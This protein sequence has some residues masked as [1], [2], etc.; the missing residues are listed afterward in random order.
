[1]SNMLEALKS[2]W[3]VSDVTTVLAHGRND[4]GR[5]FLV[6]LMQPKNHMSRKVYLPYSAETETLLNRASLPLVA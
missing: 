2:G 1:M 5:G 3:T 4:E 6:T